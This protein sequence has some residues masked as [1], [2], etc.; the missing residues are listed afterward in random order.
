M[1]FRDDSRCW[2]LFFRRLTL[3]VILGLVFGHCCRVGTV[4]AGDTPSAAAAPSAGAG[5]SAINF[6]ND[7]VPV[8]TKAGCNAGVCHAKAGGGQNGFQLSLLGFEPREDYD[9]LVRE[10]RGRRL[11]PAAPDQS[12]L[13]RKASGQVPHVG[14]VRLAST[15]TVT[16]CCV[17]GFV[18]ELRLRMIPIA[19]LAVDRSPT[20]PRQDRCTGGH[21]QL[22]AVAHYSDGSLR[23]VTALALYESNNDAMAEVS[24][25]GHVTAMRHSRQ[26]LGDGSVSRERLRS[27]TLR[28]RSGR[29]EELPPP[30]NFIDELVFANLQEIGIPPLDVVR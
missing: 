9:H 16:R 29:V 14:G 8:L 26:G 13:L 11:F 5:P 25:D 27:T 1:A 19:T 21:Q 4:S 15:S 3:A 22:K 23:D 24:A 6:V 18:R 28:S 12:L 10:G 17:S 2:G 30:N 20:I 7:V